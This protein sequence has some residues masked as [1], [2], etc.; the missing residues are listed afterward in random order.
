MQ[1]SKHLRK[2]SV[3]YLFYCPGCKEMH[4]YVTEPKSLG[5]KWTFNGNVEKPTFKPSLRL[6]TTD[7]EDDNGQKLPQPVER[8]ICHLF[9]T[10]GQIIFCGDS[11]HDLKGQTVALPELPDFASGER[12]GDGNPP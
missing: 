11:D 2:S 6:F 7:D 1:I 8:T 4:H 12:Y 9:V 10:D 3:G 5:P